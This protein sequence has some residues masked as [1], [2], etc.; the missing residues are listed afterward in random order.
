MRPS[1]SGRCAGRRSGAP[2]SAMPEV[3]EQVAQV[4]DAPV[5][6]VAERRVAGRLEPVQVVVG[7][8][9]QLAGRDDVVDEQAEESG[10]PAPSP[11]D[12]AR[13]RQPPTR[14]RRTRRTAPRRRPSGAPCRPARTGARP[15]TGDGRSRTR[16]R[17]CGPSSRRGRRRGRG[18]RPDLPAAASA[19][20][21]DRVHRR[22]RVR[23]DGETDGQEGQPDRDD[24]RL[25]P[26]RRDLR[27]EPED[28]PEG[29]EDRRREPHRQARPA[30]VRSPTSRSRR[31]RRPGP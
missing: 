25:V 15:G 23:P 11:A 1:A 4:L 14:R 18:R 26:G 29:E 16:R 24:M 6:V 13:P 2:N 28:G 7:G 8:A 10:A 20:A 22:D 31:R 9:D 19:L 30:A 27:R 12:Q 21:V 5:G 3:L 17:G